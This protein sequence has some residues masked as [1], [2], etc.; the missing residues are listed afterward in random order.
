MSIPIATLAMVLLW[1]SFKKVSKSVNVAVASFV[2][3][4]IEVA[5]AA[6]ATLSTLIK[7]VCTKAAITPTNHSHDD[8]DDD[9]MLVTWSL[10]IVS[11]NSN[12]LTTKR[13]VHCKIK[14]NKTRSQLAPVTP[15]EKGLSWPPEDDLKV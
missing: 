7:E 2:G 3:D 8:D 1:S 12:I 13:V 10:T 4:D 5:A 14:F 11:Y 9:T 15:H 6:A